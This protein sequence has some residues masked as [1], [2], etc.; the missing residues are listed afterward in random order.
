MT[1][2]KKHKGRKGRPRRRTDPGDLMQFS[3]KI[4]ARLIDRIQAVATKERRS[5]AAQTAVLLESHPA[6]ADP[7]ATPPG[8]EASS[9]AGEGSE[10]TISGPV[11]S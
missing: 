9:S 6:L 3:V 11:S 5:I 4:E 2:P 8:A 10:G 7:A 1:Q